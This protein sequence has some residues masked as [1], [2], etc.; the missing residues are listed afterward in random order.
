MNLQ[1]RV[2]FSR[3][4]DCARQLH[5]RE[6]ARSGVTLADF[7]EILKEANSLRV[8]VGANLVAGALWQRFRAATQLHAA[9]CKGKS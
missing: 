6:Y 9:C 3:C 2:R 5:L 1:T 8:N 4:A 7:D